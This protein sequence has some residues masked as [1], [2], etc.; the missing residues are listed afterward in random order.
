MIN[1]KNIKNLEDLR[2]AKKELKSQIAKN[3]ANTKK[4][5]LYNSVNKLFSTVETKTK[6][7]HSLVGSGVNG[8]LHY[9]SKKASHKMHLGKTGQT[10]LSLAI[11]VATPIIAKKIQHFIDKKL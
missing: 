9:L 6:T 2:K 10:I 7:N 3:D 5:F 11:I 8:T 4:S 1:M